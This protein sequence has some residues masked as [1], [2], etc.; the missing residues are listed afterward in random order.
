MLLELD[1]TTKIVYDVAMEIMDVTCFL[2][3][4]NDVTDK[5]KERLL[6]CHYMAFQNRHGRSPQLKIRE[7]VIQ[8]FWTASKDERKEILRMVKD[9]VDGCRQIL[10]N[11]PKTLDDWTKYCS[12]RYGIMLKTLCALFY[13]KDQLDRSKKAKWSLQL[14]SL[15]LGT[16]LG[17]ASCVSGFVKDDESRHCAFPSV[18]WN[19]ENIKNQAELFHPKNKKFAVRAINTLIVSSFAEMTD[20]V[21]F[22]SE[23]EEDSLLGRIMAYD[24]I[25]SMNNLM[26]K[27][28]HPFATTSLDL[29]DLN[30][31]WSDI[32]RVLQKTYSRAKTAIGEIQL[33]GTVLE[34]HDKTQQRKKKRKKTSM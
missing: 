19:N 2:I 11:P 7:D 13:A 30:A 24:V 26:S 21:Y 23:I 32:L 8:R 22:L 33:E 9:M 10:Y 17:K 20:A 4:W 1:A 25:L 12:S 15:Q 27:I 29:T 14:G 3:N 16:F 18:A 6:H 5:V 28:N 31:N 34:V